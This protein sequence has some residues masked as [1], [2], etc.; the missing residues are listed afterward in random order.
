MQTFYVYSL[1]IYAIHITQMMQLQILSII[2]PS[3]QIKNLFTHGTYFPQDFKITTHNYLVLF[4]LFKILII[5]ITS[6]YARQKAMY[7]ML[8]EQLD[9]VSLTSFSLSVL[10]QLAVS[11]IDFSIIKYDFLLITSLST[12]NPCSEFTYHMQVPS[13][14][15]ESFLKIFSFNTIFFVTVRCIKS[16]GSII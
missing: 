7:F 16:T 15:Y 9:C 11:I 12:C 14:S 1:R 5:L 3:H 4:F 6:M 10:C 2:L 13:R 8:L